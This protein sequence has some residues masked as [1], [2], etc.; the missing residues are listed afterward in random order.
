ML[1]CNVAH[2][3]SI[4]G[5]RTSSESGQIGHGTTATGML[6]LLNYE[7]NADLLGL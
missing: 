6:I 2:V 7:Q 3:R 1:G 4:P 5:S